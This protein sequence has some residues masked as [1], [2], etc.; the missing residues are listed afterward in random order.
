MGWGRISHLFMLQYI[1]GTS[2][3]SVYTSSWPA[4]LVLSFLNTE[5][6]KSRE[7]SGL[8][9]GAETIRAPRADPPPKATPFPAALAL[10]ALSDLQE[11]DRN[12]TFK[13]TVVAF[14][15]GFTALPEEAVPE[16]EVEK[17]VAAAAICWAT[18]EAGV[19]AQRNWGAEL[20][21]LWLYSRRRRTCDACGDE[22]SGPPATSRILGG[23][24]AWFVSKL[25][26]IGY[27]RPKPH[28]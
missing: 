11:D 9:A 6:S 4:R 18:G 24:P 13:A 10:S 1:C 2:C 27:P 5:V 15:D 21:I 20:L 17:E 23:D 8:M 3:A 7:V 22:A 16:R 14:G 19:E 12:P 25:T 26:R 28:G